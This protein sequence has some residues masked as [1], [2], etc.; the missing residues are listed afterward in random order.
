MTSG[1]I[2]C[3]E[4]WYAEILHLDRTVTRYCHMLRRPSVE[5]GD[6]VITGQIIG[7]V[8]NSGHSSG[9]H[10]HLEAH[11]GQPAIEANAL[12][13]VGYFAARGVDLTQDTR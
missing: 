5:V 1:K 2:R 3:R 6:D 9:P 10:L 11:S 4:G 8:G 12:D 7:L 13:P